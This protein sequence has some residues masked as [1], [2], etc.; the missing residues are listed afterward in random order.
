MG[1]Q[2]APRRSQ[3]SQNFI[4]D[5]PKNHARKPKSSCFGSSSMAQDSI[6]YRLKLAWL[7]TRFYLE[8]ACETTFGALKSTS[9][10]R[11]PNSTDSLLRPQGDHKL[12]AVKANRK[13]LS[14]HCETCFV[15]AAQ[16]HVINGCRL[17]IYNIESTHKNQPR[18]IPLSSSRE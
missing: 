16:H 6:S 14:Q 3:F 5:I 9:T 7:K 10:A 18:K 4:A 8:G 11:V 12:T 13:V 15:V 17:A 1:S 2:L